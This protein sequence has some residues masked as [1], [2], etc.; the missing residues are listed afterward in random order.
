[1]NT[2]E[3]VSKGEN[4][5][6]SKHTG[7]E[8]PKSN[9]YAKINAIQKDMSGY[10]KRDVTIGNERKNYKGVSH[11][12]VTAHIRAA[13]IKHGVVAFPS[14]ESHEM[15]SFKDKYGNNVTRCVATVHVTYVDCDNPESMHTIKSVGIGD[16]Y[17]DKASGKAYSYAA[18]NAHLK[19]F[20]LETGENDESR[21]EIQESINQNE[22]KVIR[23]LLEKAAR[24]KASVSEESLIMYLN[25]QY[26]LS[27]TAIEE[28][29][30]HIYPGILKI[31][32]V[33]GN[34]GPIA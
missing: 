30:K 6:Y 28:I 14:M 1:M 31:L 24:V 4:Y 17:G 22:A 8:R 15:P 7:E 10:I 26:N 25:N 11:D 18:K 2:D 3:I 5:A 34:K 13:M 21:V 33:K 9:I 32:H 29:P 12:A 27:M 20:N 16:D 19:V 23:E